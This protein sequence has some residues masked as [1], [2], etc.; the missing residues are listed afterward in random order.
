MLAKRLERIGLCIESGLVWGVG[1]A[2]YFRKLALWSSGSLRYSS[3]SKFLRN[4]TSE[5][6]ISEI[7][8][9]S[10]NY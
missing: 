10:K 4:S 2:H 8:I 7:H 9:I 1:L 5:T 3:L 6:L